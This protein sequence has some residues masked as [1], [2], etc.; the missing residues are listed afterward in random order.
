MSITVRKLPDGYRELQ[1]SDEQPGPAAVERY[2]RESCDALGVMLFKPGSSLPDVNI[3]REL[4]GLKSV[5]LNGDIRDCTAVFDVP[6]LL[7]LDILHCRPPRHVLFDRLPR[8]EA[9]D[10][11]WGPAGGETIA[12]LTALEWLYLAEWDGEHLPLGKAPL[13]RL[14][15]ECRRNSVL[16]WPDLAPVADVLEE[17]D[18]DSA[19]IHAEG[20]GVRLAALRTLTL[21]RCQLPGL[22]FLAGAAELRQLTLEGCGAIPSLTPLAELPHLEILVVGGSTHVV[23]GDLEALYRMPALREVALERG[24]PNY[25]RKPAQVRRDFP[26]T[27]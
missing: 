9:L 10:F 25:S 13:R 26:L 8:L 2:H 27:N 1:V 18:I 14:R 7:R 23:D 21:E 4:P 3:V 15:L 12:S 19:K 22:D 20:A 16:H 11:A 5:R 6:D 24:R 17:I